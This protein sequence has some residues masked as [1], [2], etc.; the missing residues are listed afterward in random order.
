[1]GMD[2]R[3]GMGADFYMSCANRGS[4][5]RSV[6]RLAGRS[7][8]DETC[9]GL[10]QELARGQLAEGFCV[11]RWG[12]DPGPWRATRFGW[13]GILGVGNQTI[14]AGR[15]WMTMSGIAPSFLGDGPDLLGFC[16]PAG[17]LWGC[18]ARSNVCSC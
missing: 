14:N 5:T 1:M 6:S 15:G 4:V 16:G 18:G 12:R 10:N 3:F 13:V 7:L 11:W 17:N 9:L 2:L 8:C